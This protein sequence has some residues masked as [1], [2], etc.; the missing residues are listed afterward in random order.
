VLGGGPAGLAAAIEA[1][2]AGAQVTLVDALPEPGGQIWRSQFRKGAKGD[3]ARCFEALRSCPI[4]LTMRTR[5]ISAPSPGLLAAESP[6]GPITLAYDRLVLATGARERFLPF[7]GWTLPGVTGA[8]GLQAMAKSGLDLKHRRVVVSGS[9]PLLLAVAAHLRRS[10]ARV[11]TVAEQAPL[12]QLRPFAKALLSQP[13]KLLQAA[14]F[15][16]LPYRTGSWVERAEGRARLEGVLLRTGSRQRWIACDFLACG[17]GLIPSL[18]AAQM[19]GCATREGRVTVDEWQRTSVPG[20]FA[21]GEITGVGGETKALLEGRIAGL[22]AV[23]RVEQARGLLPGMNA[24]RRF[25]DALRTAFALRPELRELPEPSTI[26]CRCEDVPFADL[27]ACAR[28]RDARLHAR[29]GMGPCQG[30]T[31]GPATAYHFGWEPGGPRLP[32]YPA[33]FS[34]LMQGTE[35]EP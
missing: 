32:L 17:F 22:S 6:A 15:M 33:S 4:T 27:E 24:Q 8:G 7:P 2:R 21:A 14:A 13:S 20:I 19:M 26:V 16:G 35:P 30:R 31:C 10:G 34:A 18:E 9:G 29:C 3:A 23:G 28:G 25:A 12:A 5:I 11:V 1:S